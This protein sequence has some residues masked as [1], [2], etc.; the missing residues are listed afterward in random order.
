MQRLTFLLIEMS[1]TYVYFMDTFTELNL[2]FEELAEI[3]EKDKI[4]PFEIVKN[5]IKKDLG[6]IK[7]VD[8]YS[9]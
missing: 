8:L 6:E 9:R 4:K 2:S 3:F 5:S 7:C 1:R